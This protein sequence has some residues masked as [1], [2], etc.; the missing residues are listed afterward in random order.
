[1]RKRGFTVVEILS[2]LAIIGIL[3]LLVMPKYT[4]YVHH[5][6]ET[7]IKSEIKIY[8]NMVDLML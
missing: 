1:M 5:A 6:K 3:I 7:E 4:M 8:E 2:V